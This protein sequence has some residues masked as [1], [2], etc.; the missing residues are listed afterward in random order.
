MHDYPTPSEAV[1]NEIRTAIRSAPQVLYL[2]GAGEDL[3][4]LWDYSQLNLLPLMNPNRIKCYV[5]GYPAK[6]F[7]E[8]LGRFGEPI[9]KL[10]T[11]LLVRTITHGGTIVLEEI[12]EAVTWAEGW[13]LAL[14]KE[15]SENVW[16][17][18][19]IS[20][21]L[22]GVAPHWDDN[23]IVIIQ[24]EGKR[25]W[26]VSSPNPLDPIAISSQ[27]S[28]HSD[29]PANYSIH[30]GDSLYVPRGYIHSTK[31]PTG[32]RSTHLMFAFRRRTC[33]DFLR[34]AIDNTAITHGALRR[35]LNELA[36]DNLTSALRVIQEW[37]VEE[38]LD[39][40]RSE[41]E[42]QISA[43]ANSRGWWRDQPD[44]FTMEDLE[45][46]KDSKRRE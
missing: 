16:E 7:V 18:L 11:E 25:N 34:W 4:N 10:D 8:D 33:W 35:D 20:Y 15:L 45:I 29:D 9:S 26:T 14:E 32:T 30:P 41:R 5:D 2:A 19:F 24:L 38:L 22:R 28:G 36:I 17:N 6:P 12:R 43:K 3:A 37:S 27:P 31:A 39:R 46:H 40:Y 44:G 42:E 21:G 1:L 13:A 23:D